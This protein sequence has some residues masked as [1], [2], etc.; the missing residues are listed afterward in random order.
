L[1]KKPGAHG[2]SE[3][4]DENKRTKYSNKGGD[5]GEKGR[6]MRNLRIS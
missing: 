5:R 2:F 6:T 1:A 3:V 4:G